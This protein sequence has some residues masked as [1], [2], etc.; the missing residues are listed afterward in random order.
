MTAIV[1]AQLRP[2]RP[3]SGQIVICALW[4]HRGV[5][6]VEDDLRN[7]LCLLHHGVVAPVFA[8]DGYHSILIHALKK[9]E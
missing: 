3:S 1:R 8:A 2:H 9:D 7:V 4:T 6:P 5:L